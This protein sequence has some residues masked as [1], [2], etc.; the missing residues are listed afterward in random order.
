MS[1]PL[2]VAFLASFGLSQMQM[3]DLTPCNFFDPAQQ[4]CSDLEKK[5]SQCSVFDIP[6]TFDNGCSPTGKESGKFGYL[7]YSC[8]KDQG[9][10]QEKGG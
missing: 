9:V 1:L 8:L 7:F 5:A 10:L 2:L 3:F 4:V 6:V